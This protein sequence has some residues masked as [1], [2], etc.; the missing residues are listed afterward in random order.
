MKKVAIGG[1]FF[2]SGVRKERVCLCRGQLTDLACPVPAATHAISHWQ[3]RA[4]KARAQG[5]CQQGGSYPWRPRSKEGKARL[6][7]K[8]VLHTAPRSTP[9]RDGA[10]RQER[11]VSVL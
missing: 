5:L 2:K 6:K 3:Q 8:A 10:S 9:S 4:P 11:V 7:C 1:T